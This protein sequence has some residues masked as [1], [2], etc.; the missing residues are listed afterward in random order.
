[1][2]SAKMRAFTNILREAGSP[3]IQDAV[4]LK[5]LAADRYQSIGAFSRRSSV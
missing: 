3:Q 4:E 1:M 5:Q 2:G